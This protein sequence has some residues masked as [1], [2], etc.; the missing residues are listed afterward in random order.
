MNQPPDTSSPEPRK[1]ADREPSPPTPKPRAKGVRQQK[2]RGSVW[3]YLGRLKEPSRASLVIGAI[4]LVLTVAGLVIAIL[5]FSGGS[6]VTPTAATSVTGSATTREPSAPKVYVNPEAT[7]DEY[8]D[9]AAQVEGRRLLVGSPGQL[10][11]GPAVELR[12]LP[13]GKYSRIV[14]A[15]QGDVLNVST[16][17][18]NTEYGSLGG[19]SVTTSISTDR[20]QCW[21]IIVSAKE[22]GTPDRE[23]VWDPVLIL[24]EHGGPTSLEYVAGS[25]VLMEEDGRI[26]GGVLPDG[27]V[28]NWISLPYEIPGGKTYYL[29]FELRIATGSQPQASAGG[30]VSR[31]RPSRRSLAARLPAPRG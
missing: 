3:G 18:G 10:A 2:A 29:N 16:Q 7:C 31:A 25:T 6:A 21:R 20:G 23:V 26:L 5:Q 19:L 14:K 28:G 12:R 11:G 9:A 4:S 13:G 1:H 22:P 24:L 17:L 15:M 8:A 27:I 30:H